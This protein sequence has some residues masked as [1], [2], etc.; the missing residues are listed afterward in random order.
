MIESLAKN[1]EVWSGPLLNG[2]ILTVFLTFT[3]FAVGLSLG[4]VL[5]LARLNRKLWYFYWPAQTFVELIRGTP[6]IV[7]LFYLFFVLP[8]VGITMDPITTGILGLGINYGAYMSEVYRGGIEAV[9]RGQWEAA[10]ALAMPTSL[11]MRAVVLPQAFRIIIPPMGNYFVALFKDTAIV[12]T[13]SITELLFT[14]RLIAS[15]TF[16]Y[17]QVYTIVLVIYFVISYPASR[18]VAR[19]ERYMRIADR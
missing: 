15:Q 8:F 11:I 19:L 10:H 5:A 1:L 4:L 2:T 12:A 16:Q 17:L 6:L 7:Q 3:S 14:A 9:E 13:I 18:A